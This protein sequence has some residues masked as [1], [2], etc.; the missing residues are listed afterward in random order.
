M[1][2]TIAIL[3]VLVIGM[4]GVW[5]ADDATLLLTTSVAPQTYIF[6]SDNSFT[7]EMNTFQ[8]FM[9]NFTTQGMRGVT[10]TT[11]SASYIA[12][13]LNAVS[14][15]G[16]PV[17]LQATSQT[18]GKLHFMTNANAGVSVKMK[19]SVLDSDTP[20]TNP[21]VIN[22]SVLVNG[23]TVAASVGAATESTAI[24]LAG[25]AGALTIASHNIDVT[26]VESDYLNAPADTYNGEI[27]FNFITT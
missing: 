26:L 1:K 16:T 3:L 18:V 4:V 7:T 25:S 12:S 6:V 22:Y 10:G 19:A 24:G 13:A 2:K 21:K 17:V 15:P 8:E 23:V 11:G 9:A 20:A 14:V 5:A 27:Y